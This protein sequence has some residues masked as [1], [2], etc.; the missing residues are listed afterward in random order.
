MQDI[1]PVG[2]QAPAEHE[3]GGGSSDIPGRILL[4]VKPARVCRPS[5]LG[6]CRR[7]S[8]TAKSLY[9]SFNGSSLR[10][11]GVDSAAAEG[12][13]QWIGRLQFPKRPLAAGTSYYVVLDLRICV[14]N[15]AKNEPL[16][17]HAAWTVVRFRHRMSLKEG[18]VIGKLVGRRPWSRLSSVGYEV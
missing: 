13:D 15:L 9:Q 1:F 5:G 16:E 17:L 7:G 18:I 14:P 2:P 8:R 3:V 4:Q 6:R 10:S 11:R 12:L